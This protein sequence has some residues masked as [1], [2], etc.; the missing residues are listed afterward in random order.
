M[1]KLYTVA[2]TIFYT[3]HDAMVYAK[4]RYSR[5]MMDYEVTVDNIYTEEEK[6]RKNREKKLKRILF[7]G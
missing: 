4:Y 3:Y 7:N 6:K 2:H 1:T 5:G